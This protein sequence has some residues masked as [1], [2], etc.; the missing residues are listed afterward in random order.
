MFAEKFIINTKTNENINNNNNNK[1]KNQDINNK[2]SRLDFNSNSCKVEDDDTSGGSDVCQA[3][4]DCELL[5][6]KRPLINLLDLTTTKTI[7]TTQFERT[8]TETTTTTTKNKTK[9][10]NNSLLNPTIDNKTT[11]SEQSDFKMRNLAHQYEPMQVKTKSIENTLLPL[12]EQV[13]S[14]SFTTFI[15]KEFNLNFFFLL[16]KITT[17]V[18]YKDSL[19]NAY[20]QAQ[21]HNNDNN[22]QRNLFFSSTAEN[23]ANA[24]FKVGEAVN[25]A[26]E[27][28]VL[29]G[30]TIAND[31]SNINADMLEACKEARKS[32]LAIKNHTQISNSVLSVLNV[33][34]N[35]QQRTISSLITSDTLK[36]IQSAN[37]LLN[38]VTKV[39]LLADVVII[40]QIINAKNRVVSTLKKIEKCSDFWTFVQL[41]SQYGTDLI[42]LA[43]LSGERQ[44]DLKVCY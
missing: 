37:S 30:E 16:L 21:L 38:S 44:N 10:D 3:E 6:I 7:T 18:N 42:E 5:N 12:V 26:V 20:L 40:N 23:S 25:M 9:Y 34:N 36:L 22:S 19:N 11:K 35:K 24:F 28:F 31:N 39:L 1:K 27:R 15:R 41:F 33:L 13:S 29:V 8:N 43:H 14:F 2:E 4:S 32:G 17:L